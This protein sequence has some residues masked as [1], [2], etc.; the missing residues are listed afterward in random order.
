MVD[1]KNEYIVS[2]KAPDVAGHY[3]LSICVKDGFLPASLNDNRV[4]LEVEE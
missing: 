4:E 3:A 2:A 1:C